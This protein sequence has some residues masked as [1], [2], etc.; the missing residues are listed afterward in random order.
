MGTAAKIVT[1]S[2]P[3]VGMVSVNKEDSI[4]GFLA[5]AF[6]IVVWCNTDIIELLYVK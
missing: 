6:V 4:K 5:N 1:A 2:P 3:L